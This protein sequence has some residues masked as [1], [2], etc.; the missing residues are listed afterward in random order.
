MEAANGSRSERLLIA[1]HRGWASEVCTGALAQG[2]TSSLMQD[3]SAPILSVKKLESIY[4][5][6]NISNFEALL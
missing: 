3:R 5:L 6:P 4:K 1:E 2:I